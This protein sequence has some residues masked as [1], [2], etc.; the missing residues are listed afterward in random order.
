MRLKKDDGKNIHCGAHRDPAND[1]KDP[2]LGVKDVTKPRILPLALAVSVACAGVNAQE[3]DTARLDEIIVTAQKREE[4]AQDIPITVNHVT[5]A[6]MREQG[7]ETLKDVKQLIPGITVRE[8][9]DPR[10]IGLFIRGIGSLQAFIGIEPD[11]AVIVDGEVLAR[12]SSLFGDVHDIE[13]VSV[14]KG[15]QGTLFGK[16]TVA[17]AMV[18]TTRRP[19]LTETSG[20]VRLNIA[21]SGDEGLGEYH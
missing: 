11:A 16:N 21:E 14:L 17:G 4:N 5:G 13:S 15:P 9:N 8:N 3:A 12:N 10:N 1:V 20:N 18:V 6:M 2:A 19:S 7:I